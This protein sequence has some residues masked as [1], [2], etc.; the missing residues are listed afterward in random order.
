MLHDYFYRLDL[1]ELQ[2]YFKQASNFS[3]Y[4]YIRPPIRPIL[5]ICYSVA[6]LQLIRVYYA[7]M[8]VV[9]LPIL[10]MIV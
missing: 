9:I 5:V 6:T 10:I 1:Y 3:L 8:I 4:C 7:V 2:V